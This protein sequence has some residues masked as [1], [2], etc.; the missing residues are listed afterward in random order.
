[1]ELG[2]HLEAKPKVM[3][4]NT[5]R[6]QTRDAQHDPRLQ[7]PC[8]AL[9]RAGHLACTFPP[10]KAPAWAWILRSIR[11][12]ESHDGHATPLS[13]WWSVRQLVVPEHGQSPCTAGT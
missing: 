5:L 10:R 9:W 13:F 7:G 6:P 8:I 1:M 4:K 11:P 3:Y 12:W 2:Q